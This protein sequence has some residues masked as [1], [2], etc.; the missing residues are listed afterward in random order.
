[1]ARGRNEICVEWLESKDKGKTN[2][3][4]V[5]HV[6]GDLGEV[7]KDSVVTLRFN[8]HR[9][10]ARVV[11]LLDPKPP[12]Q[13]RKKRSSV[14]KKTTKPK[15]SKRQQKPL[16]LVSARPQRDKRTVHQCLTLL[17]GWSLERLKRHPE[18]L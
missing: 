17:E 18:E 13:R 12:E 2:Q 10:Q 5:K 15:A 4:N 9:Y 3:V 8:S 14:A 11:D 16:F 6:I 7:E 1:M